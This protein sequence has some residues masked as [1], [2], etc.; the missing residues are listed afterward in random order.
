ML[1]VFSCAK[2]HSGT[3]GWFF[4]HSPFVSS[5]LVPVSCQIFTYF[6]IK[7]IYIEL[8]LT[9]KDSPQKKI[10]YNTWT[11]RFW[12]FGESLSI[13]S[14]HIHLG[15]TSVVAKLSSKWVRLWNLGS[16]VQHVYLNCMSYTRHNIKKKSQLHSKFIYELWVRM[17]HNIHTTFSKQRICALQSILSGI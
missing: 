5:R 3:V 15:C 12:S 13:S 9:R 4:Q 11:I 14:N 17:M 2:R 1:H 8:E 10:I 16:C 7:L 6:F